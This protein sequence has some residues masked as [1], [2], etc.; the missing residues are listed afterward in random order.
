MDLLTAVGLL[1][2]LWHW[3]ARYAPDG[4]ISRYSWAVIASGV[5]WRGDAE[6]M[7]DA[8][9]LCRWIDV[10]EMTLIHDWSEHCENYVRKILERRGMGFADGAPTRKRLSE[11]SRA[12]VGTMSGQ[13]SD[14][15]RP[16]A[17]ALPSHA[18][19]PPNPR[20]GGMTER[21]ETD[22]SFARF[23]AAY[24]RKVGKL[25][26][27]RAFAKARGAE[28]L[29]ALLAALALQKTSGEWLRDSGRFIP[30]PATWLNQGRW[31]DELRPAA[32]ALEERLERS[33]RSGVVIDE[34]EE[35][36]VGCG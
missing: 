29:E 24:P 22:E 36:E 35:E 1:E 5:H 34:T 16:R 18:Y 9:V 30:H 3:V 17:R 19:I 26:A 7:R 32:G 28:R 15:V 21:G 20:S 10:G 11:N 14:N 13:R 4:D 2:S 23:W 12:D 33:R 31:E 6:K 27:A 25:A 8:L